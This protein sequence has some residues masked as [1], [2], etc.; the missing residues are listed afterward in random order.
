MAGLL[1]MQIMYRL[2][3]FIYIYKASIKEVKEPYFENI[4][5]ADYLL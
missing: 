5:H 2:L 4:R 1:D 3:K